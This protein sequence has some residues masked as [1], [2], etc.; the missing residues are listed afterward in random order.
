MLRKQLLGTSR[1]RLVTLLQHHQQ[2]TV[3]EIAAH[4]G[5]TVNAVRPQVTGMERDGVVRKIGQRHGATRP[6]H[7]YALTPEVEHLLSQAYMPLLAQLVRVFVDRLPS[8]QV[9]ALFAESGRHLADELLAG[10]KLTGPLESRVRAASELINERLG[11]LTHVEGN[12]GYVIRGVGCPLAAVTGTH[13]A[14]CLAMQQLVSEVVGLP[15][16]ECCERAGRPRC[17]FKVG[18]RTRAA[19]SKK[20]GDPVPPYRQRLRPR[21]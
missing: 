7:L 5:L 4:L 21:R 10:K 17:C 20:S 18:S 13:A 6:S 3:D 2:L 1:G 12:G 15:V 8:K 19:V 9:E 14:V 11:A 16:Q